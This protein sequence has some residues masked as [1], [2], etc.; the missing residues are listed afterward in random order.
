MTPEVTAARI[1]LRVCELRVM[2]ATTALL[3]WDRML[4][5]ERASGPHV[6][7]DLYNIQVRAPTGPHGADV[8]PWAGYRALVAPD[9]LTPPKV[10]TSRVRRVHPSPPSP[11]S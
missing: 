9:C 1:E 11:R 2:A 5:R 8:P 7:D 10:S 6:P 4:A 3:F